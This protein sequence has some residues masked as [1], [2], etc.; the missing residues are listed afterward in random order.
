MIEDNYIRKEIIQGDFTMIVPEGLCEMSDA[1]AQIKYPAQNRPQVILTNET[2]TV[3]YKFTY[4][5]EVV[6]T[7]AL[8]EL[9]KQTKINLKRVFT[10]IEYYEEKIV[11]RNNT[12][13]GWFDYTSP[14]IGGKLYNISFFTWIKGKLLQ[15]TFTC[16]YTNVC[17]W[18]ASFIESIMS[19]GERE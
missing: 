8:E 11:V 17:D 7:E 2:S 5:N 3:D 6:D 1:I 12:R 14:A 18:R 10:G 4:I 16:E 19:I 15:G 13:L 9:V